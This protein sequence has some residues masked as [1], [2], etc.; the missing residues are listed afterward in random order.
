MQKKEHVVGVPY[1]IAPTKHPAKN[2]FSNE[3]SQDGSCGAL[4]LLDQ[5]T[6]EG[7]DIIQTILT[8]QQCSEEG[9]R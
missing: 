4:G 8:E 3:Y 6:S 1:N 9:P 5:G 2:A 7:S